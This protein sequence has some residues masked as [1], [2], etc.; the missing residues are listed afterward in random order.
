MLLSS[1]GFIR[2]DHSTAGRKETLSARN[3]GP[4][5]RS[6]ATSTQGV[7]QTHFR[8]EL[9]LPILSPSHTSIPDPSP[10]P[11]NPSSYSPTLKL[12]RRAVA[13]S[14]LLLPAC[15]SPIHP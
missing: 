13:Q 12:F 2:R 9:S 5:K 1:R 4:G 11:R 15:D 10:P 6:V 7:S 3:D 8:S 14:L